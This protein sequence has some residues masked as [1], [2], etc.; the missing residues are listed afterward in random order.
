MKPILFI[1]ALALLFLATSSSAATVSQSPGSSFA[2]SVFAGV[3]GNEKY[4]DGP[5]AD[6]TDGC[7]ARAAKICRDI[8]DGA[9]G[10]LPANCHL[11]MIYSHEPTSGEPPG[12]DWRYHVAC[13]IVCEGETFVID[14]T[15]SGVTSGNGWHDTFGGDVDV[16]PPSAG[17][18]DTTPGISDAELQEAEDIID[19]MN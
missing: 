1:C 3:S 18:G 5:T 7:F 10:A 4:G 17:P 13:M 12:V 2:D 8:Q 6:Q 15:Q 11:A 16:T 19:R 9:F 14:P